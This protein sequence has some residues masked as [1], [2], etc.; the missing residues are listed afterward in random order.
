MLHAA[1]PSSISRSA[2]VQKVYEADIRHVNMPPS[3]CCETSSSEALISRIRQVQIRLN[4]ATGSRDGWHPEC[5]AAT[6][7][8]RYVPVLKTDAAH[9]SETAYP[10]NHTEYCSIHRFYCSI[11]FGAANS[12]P[13][14]Q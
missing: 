11:S 5:G 3:S 8:A 2:K 12:G 4:C 1:P 14:A 9:F 10:P 13:K 6:Q 7:F